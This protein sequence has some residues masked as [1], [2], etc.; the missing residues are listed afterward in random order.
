MVTAPTVGYGDMYPTTGLGKLAYMILIIGSAYIV[1]PL[2]IGHIIIRML[3][4][5]HQ[6]SDEEQERIEDALI[7][8]AAKGDILAGE[9][10]QQI[11]KSHRE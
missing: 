7:V 11:L 10:V 4:D 5:P 1:S 6:F 2:I 8:I 9:R 3:P